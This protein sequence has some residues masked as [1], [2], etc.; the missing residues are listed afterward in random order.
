MIECATS[1]PTELQFYTFWDFYY[2][3]VNMSLAR[4]LFTSWQNLTAFAIGNNKDPIDLAYDDFVRLLKDELMSVL[5]PS[6]TFHKVANSLF[7]DDQETKKVSTA[8]VL[9][10]SKWKKMCQIIIMQ[11]STK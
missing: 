7:L 5:V 2:E 9:F 10:T 1:N 3:K 4:K 11:S 6:K 8:S